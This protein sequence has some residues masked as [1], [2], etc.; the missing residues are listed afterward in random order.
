MKTTMR[1]LALSAATLIALTGCTN[2]NSNNNAGN[3]ADAGNNT[4]NQ[5]Q[6]NHENHQA[7]NA[8]E[9]GAENGAENGLSAKAMRDSSLIPS[10]NG[11]KSYT[12][13]NLG[14][15]TYGLGSS[16]YSMIGSSGLHSTG[17][18]AHLESRL[19]GAGI[20]D[21]RV[22]VFDDT[23]VLATEKNDASASS[24]DQLQRKLLDP[25]EGMSGKGVAP[26]EGLGGVTGANTSA[27]DNLSMA[28]S[29]IKT[30]MGA[31]V[32]VLTVEG[33]A[34]VQA[35]DKIRADALAANMSPEQIGRDISTLL[36]LVKRGQQ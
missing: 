31:E 5:E 16:V 22:F 28:A 18:S 10:E 34:A 8:T 35:I 26:G 11:Q 24:Y 29:Q 19:S 7:E 36:N 15:T 27:H 13:N 9:N 25:A 32:K 17:F 1:L 21:V 3:N 33:A 12:T 14:Q 6:N 30:M 20:P 2:N 4:E 23:V